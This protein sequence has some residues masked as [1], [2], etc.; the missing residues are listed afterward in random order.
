MNLRT[1]KLKLMRPFS[2]GDRGLTL[3]EII[4]VVTLL[5]TLMT[6]IIRNLTGQQERAKSD[7]AKLAMASLSQD[8]QMYKLDNGKY[9]SSEQGLQALV[10]DPGSAKKWRG[11]YSEDGKLKD[12]WGLDFGYESDGRE[13]KIVSGGPNEE[14]GDGDDVTYPEEGESKES[15][16]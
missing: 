14:V 10:S 9:P 3:V 6:I 11:P 16:E 15:K 4:I 12:P 8:L 1:L 2:R 13:F 7:Q 5:G